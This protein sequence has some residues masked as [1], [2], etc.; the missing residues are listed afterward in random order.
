M[1]LITFTRSIN[2]ASKS[3]DL[4][5]FWRGWCPCLK[6]RTLDQLDIISLILL[7]FSFTRWTPTFLHVC[8]SNS[9]TFYTFCFCIRILRNYFSQIFSIFQAYVLWVF[10]HFLGFFLFLIKVGWSLMDDEI[11][12]GIAKSLRS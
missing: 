9:T 3:K 4:W 7:S 6:F 10:P 11:P 12:H 5:Q 8:F 2:V 1:C